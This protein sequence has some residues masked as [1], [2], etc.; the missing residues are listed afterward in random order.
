VFPLDRFTVVLD[1]C[2]MFPMLVRDVL[3]TLADHEFFSPKWSP[4][5]ND[6]WTRNLLAR[7]TERDGEVVAKIKVD[8]IASAVTSAFPDALV[9]TDLSE[10]PILDPVDAKDRHVVL[11]AIAAQ[12]DA[13]VTFNI[14]DFAVA[15]L[16]EK[17]RIEVIH[18]DDFVMDLVDLNEKRAVAAFRELRARKKNPAWERTELIRRL[19]EAGLVQ[20]SLW[21]NTSDVVA[22]I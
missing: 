22:L 13:I 2:T 15:H 12:A 11:T 7:M 3:L 6:E 19:R 18:P 10:P 9:S 5:I 4:R 8:R 17:L 21:L 1:A 16:A 20:T 14:A